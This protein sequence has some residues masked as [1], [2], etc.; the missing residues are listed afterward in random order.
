MYFFFF[1]MKYVT[2]CEILQKDLNIVSRHLLKTCFVAHCLSYVQHPH[3]WNSFQYF[4]ISFTS[5]TCPS[6][7]TLFNFMMSFMS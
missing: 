1:D 2:F 7:F 5:L 3:F 6:P 4:L